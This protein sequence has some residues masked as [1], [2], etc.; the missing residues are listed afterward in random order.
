VSAFVVDRSTIDHLVSALIASAIVKEAEADQ[1]GRIL[2]AENHKSVNARYSDKTRAPKY[3]HSEHPTDSAAAIL[4][5]AD[6]FEY[7]ACEHP[8][9][10]LSAARAWLVALRA[11]IGHVTELRKSPAYQAAAWG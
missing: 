2:W 3:A 11:T 4:K 1:V 5:A 8:G 10:R 9:W 6:C 7:Q